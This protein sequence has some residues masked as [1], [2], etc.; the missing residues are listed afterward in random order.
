MHKVLFNTLSFHILFNMPVC[1]SNGDIVLN[2]SYSGKSISTFNPFGLLR[3]NV[4]SVSS[5]K[6][7]GKKIAKKNF[8]RKK[9]VVKKVEIPK[10]DIVFTE[11]KKGCFPTKMSLTDI[12]QYLALPKGWFYHYDDKNFNTYSKID[13]LFDQVIRFGEERSSEAEMIIDWL[14][15]SEKID[16]G[17]YEDPRMLQDL[18]SKCPNKGMGYLSEFDTLYD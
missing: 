3:V 4:S 6:K 8:S 13:D 11:E 9:N 12:E 14:C 10:I 18:M 7:A 17:E 5:R 16:L 1:V 2:G 15:N